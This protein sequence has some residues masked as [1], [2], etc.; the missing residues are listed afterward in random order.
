MASV[1]FEKLKT[2]QQVKACLRHCDKDER[3]KANHS[4]KHI[5]KSLTS[6]NLQYDD[7]NYEEACKFYDERL[8]ELDSVEG[9]NKRK[10]RVTCFGL[11]IPFPKDLNEA[12]GEQWSN[13]VYDI[14]AEQY[15][16]DNI[17]N[18][19]LHRD[20]KHKY[21]RAED[22]S[23]QISRDHIH[24]YV[25]PEIDGKLNGKAFSSKQNMLK[26]NNSIQKMTQVDYG[27]DFMDGSKKKSKESVESLKNKS[28]KL[29]YSQAKKNYESKL[30]RLDEREQKL[31]DLE[32]HLNAQICDLDS[33]RDEY[34]LLEEKCLKI[35]NRAF[36]EQEKVKSLLEE[37]KLLEENIQKLKK[38]QDERMK[39]DRMYADY[40]RKEIA[41][42]QQ[43]AN[44]MANNIDTGFSTDREYS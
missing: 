19:Y 15:G 37:Q 33:K 25:I 42:R 36:R 11:E 16:E 44:S 26:L 40:R 39:S 20:E 31:N 4:N 8:A 27:I 21:L 43:R 35:E 7:V 32:K 22:G 38:E 9:A 17:V 30:K 5:D 28:E 2:A 6:N 10:D 18:I 14:V 23:Q 34:T 1:N 12:D 24:I 3:L 13:K 29:A 41:R